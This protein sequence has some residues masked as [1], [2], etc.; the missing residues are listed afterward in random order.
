MSKE[1]E[2]ENGPKIQI[3]INANIASIIESKKVTGDV[4]VPQKVLYEG[5]QIKITTIKRFAFR[6]ARFDSLIFQEDSEVETFESYI[7]INAFLKKLQIPPKLKNIDKSCF[8]NAG[9]IID[10]DVSPKNKKYFYLENKYF[11]GKSDESNDTFDILFYSRYDI[12]NAIIPPQIKIISDHAFWNHEQLNSVIFPDNSK[13]KR[14]ESGAFL[15]S[16]LSKIVLPATL[17][18][19]STDAFTCTIFLTKIEISNKNE[20]Y[21]M[22]DDTFLVGKIENSS[23]SFESIIICRKNVDSIRIPSHIKK[24]NEAAFQCCVKLGNVTF[25]PISSLEKIG[26]FGFY[27]C[28]TL[29]TII[30]PPKVESVG[31][32]CFGKCWALE[33]I[34]W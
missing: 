3:N 14:I 9:G 12:E 15:R 20:R 10:F 17:E 6:E 31:I 23:D 13:L 30:I 2:L 19:I 27:S 28:V 5:K 32:N 7:F 1:I 21:K 26:G 33:T 29:K 22:M 11:V 8:C 25:E 34:D 24:I 16:N 4:L 18:Y